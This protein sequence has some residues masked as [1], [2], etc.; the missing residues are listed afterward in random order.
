MNNLTKYLISFALLCLSNVAISEEI[1][2]SI[3]CKIL[4]QVVL[5]VV[6]GESKRYSGFGDVKIGDKTFIT[7]K[8]EERATA[9]SYRITYENDQSPQASVKQ[10]IQNSS[11][12]LIMENGRIIFKHPIRGRGEVTI[13]LGESY[14][15]LAGSSG[16]SITGRRYFKN[17]W[18]FIAQ[19]GI[20]T[21]NYIQTLNCMNVPAAYDQ[22]L[23]KIRDFHTVNPKEF[24]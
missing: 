15:R 11:Y 23:Q 18:G 21:N 17:D 9:S 8:F 3:N 13:A 24:K 7:F 16:R 19:G 20:F 22:M 10:S 14:I 2:F 12:N 4:D 1:E 6:D 5:E